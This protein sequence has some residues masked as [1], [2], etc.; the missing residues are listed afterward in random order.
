MPLQSYLLE[1]VDN[2]SLSHSHISIPCYNH[3]T[4]ASKT[5]I[6]RDLGP[7]L[8]AELLGVTAAYRQT[9]SCKSTHELIN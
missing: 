6:L 5:K 9:N 7:R 4:H 3:K 8:P 2:S 1:K